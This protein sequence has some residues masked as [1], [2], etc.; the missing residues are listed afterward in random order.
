MFNDIQRVQLRVGVDRNWERGWGYIVGVQGSVLPL[1][2]WKPTADHVGDSSDILKY[3]QSYE[4]LWVL[5]K[6][7]F[8]TLGIG[9]RLTF[10]QRSYYP[11]SLP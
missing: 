4:L 7:A 10:L 6:I 3:T 8:L 1:G 2:P 11:T 5:D 9:R